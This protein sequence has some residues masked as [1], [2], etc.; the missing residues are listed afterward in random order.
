MI[1]LWDYVEK[2]ALSLAAI[3]GSGRVSNGMLTVTG[4]FAETVFAKKSHEVSY[5]DTAVTLSVGK[6]AMLI[7]R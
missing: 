5:G 7:V 1:S 6:G 2:S 4:E 3:N